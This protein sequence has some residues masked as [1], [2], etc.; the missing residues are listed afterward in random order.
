ML[1]ER[2]VGSTATC[3]GRPSNR[4]LGS[5]E[6]APNPC[7]VGAA[8]TKGQRHGRS[9]PPPDGVDEIALECGTACWT[10]WAAATARIPAKDNAT[11]ATVSNWRMCISCLYRCPAD[12][13]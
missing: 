8:R 12:G 9:W 5:G 13:G 7:R 4:G 2:I 3:R 6:A 11:E 10:A 1:A